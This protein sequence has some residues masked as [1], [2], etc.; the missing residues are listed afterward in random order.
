[1]EVGGNRP[2]VNNAVTSPT[3]HGVPNSTSPP[4][5]PDYSYGS[6][7]SPISPYNAYPGPTSPMSPG[8]SPGG[9]PQR[10]P[11]LPKP[12]PQQHVM[13]DAVLNMAARGAPDK[14]PWSYAPDI[15]TIKEQRDKVR[16]R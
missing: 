11:P 6:P 9:P 4:G 2:Y 7:K 1:M 12:A 16:R 5:A 15:N 10:A 13:P 8:I 3:S 14:K